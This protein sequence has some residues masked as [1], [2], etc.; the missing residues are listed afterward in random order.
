MSIGNIIFSGVEK[1]KY[2]I[3]TA[4]TASYQATCSHG[5]TIQVS[6]LVRKEV[7]RSILFGFPVSYY[8]ASSFEIVTVACSEMTPLLCFGS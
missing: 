7:Y 3:D 4:E 2:L 5:E 1:K 8:E 6:S